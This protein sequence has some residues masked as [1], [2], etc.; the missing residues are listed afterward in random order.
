MTATTTL[1]DLDRGVAMLS[2]KVLMLEWAVKLMLSK[3]P[4]R[5]YIVGQ[6]RIACEQVYANVIHQPVHDA[7]L[8][9]LQAQMAAFERCLLSRQTPEATP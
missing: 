1:E 9:S 2:G 3:H 7:L 4:E 8:E 5:E 6:I